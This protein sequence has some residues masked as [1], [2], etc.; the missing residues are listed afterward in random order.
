MRTRK[1][2]TLPLAFNYNELILKHCAPT[3]AQ[4]WPKSGHLIHIILNTHEV[5]NNFVS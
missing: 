4:C 3:M 1:S 2:L 5:N